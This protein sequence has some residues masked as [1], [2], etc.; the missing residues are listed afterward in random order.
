[1]RLYPG[2][3]SIGYDIENKTDVVITI[4]GPEGEEV[5][6]TID[7][8]GKIVLTDLV[9]G[10]YYIT[11]ENME[12]ENYTGSEAEDVFKVLKA[13]P[14]FTSEVT[15]E[16]KVGENITITVKAPADATG[17]VTVTVD[18]EIVAIDI[19]VIDGVASVNVTDLA[20]GHH[21][22]EVTYNGDD[23]YEIASDLNSFDVVKVDPKIV[24]DDI[25]NAVV[26]NTVKTTVTVADG[27]ATGYV[28][29]NNVAYKLENGKAIID[30]GISEAG[31]QVITV[32]YL[33]DDKYTNGTADKAFTATRASTEITLDKETDYTVVDREVE[34]KY[35]IDPMVSKGNVTLWIDDVLYYNDEIFSSDGSIVI[36]GD[37]FKTNGTYTVKVQYIGT[38]DYA[39]SNVATL[40]IIVED[41]TVNINITVPENTTT[42][43]FNITVPTDAGGL[44]LVDVDGKHYYAP[45]ENGTASITVP[46][47]EPGNYTANVT[48]TGDEFYDGVSKTVDITIPANADENSITI[49]EGATTTNPTFSINLP[50][51]ATG[52]FEVDVDGKKYVVPVENGTA[53]IS[54][55]GLAPGNHNVTVKYSGDSKY[56]SISKSTTLKL[57]EPVPKLSENKYIKVVYSGKATY[58]V[59]LTL[60][61][62]AAAGKYVT[63]NYNGKNYNVKTD[64]KGYATLKLNTKVKPKKYT[65]T[66]TYK[67]VKVTSKV[68]VK[69]VIKAKN[70]KAKKSK[71]LNLYV[72]LKKVDGK[73]L[74]NK[75]VKLKFKG[76]KYT[77]KTNKKGKAKFT[78]KKKVMQKLK[79]GKKYKYKVY[80]GKD[81]VTKKIKVKK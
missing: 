61:G 51:D 79:K 10:E 63:I 14:T 23:N 9:A 56:N 39:D 41:E 28:I 22:Y 68:K 20:A 64:S 70:K 73:V 30:V 81:K 33:G 46:G 37:Q 36:S 52:Y 69:H 65:V 26:G 42:P 34:V 77:A 48:Y 18:G 59:R 35:T 72:K 66:A 12:N 75:K 11:I 29:Y 7:D 47:L 45:V 8:E 71:K 25:E 1:M 57:K 38:D 62:K 4:N 17:N 3:F 78:I 19:P 74:K 6:Y 60:D 32:E 43:V 67:G 24:I 53:K 49:P 16:A 58:K 76:K 5:P 15:K 54:V 55:P 80:Y 50:S 31:T 27:N 44:L 21:S 2:E 40:N 13:D